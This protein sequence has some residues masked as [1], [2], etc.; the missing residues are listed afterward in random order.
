M[1]L[2]DYPKQYF[3][4]KR[5]PIPGQLE[6][7]EEV[8]LKTEYW[9]LAISLFKSLIQQAEKYS[10]STEYVNYSSATIWVYDGIE[11]KGKYKI[12]ISTSL[13]YEDNDTTT[14]VP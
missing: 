13:E 12:E 11:Y 6:F 7:E 5:I 8:L 10:L 3:Y 14:N 4:V 9:F 1:K 2:L